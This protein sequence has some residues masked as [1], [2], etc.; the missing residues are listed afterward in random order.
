MKNAE[1]ILL[2]TRFRFALMAE[3][4]EGNWNREYHSVPVYRWKGFG[5]LIDVDSKT[6]YPFLFITQQSRLELEFLCH[7]LYAVLDRPDEQMSTARPQ[8]EVVDMMGQEILDI[9]RKQTDDLPKIIVPY[10][11]K[12]SLLSLQ[13]A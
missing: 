2:G 3:T 4:T 12:K 1:V 9:L 8:V 10:L 11:D 5:V 7:F 6:K 13:P